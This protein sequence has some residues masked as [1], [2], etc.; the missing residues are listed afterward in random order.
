MKRHELIE[1]VVTNGDSAGNKITI[2]DIEN[3]RN[4]ATQ[5]I[6]ITGIQAL[7][8][9]ALPLSP[10]GNPVWT[11]A[12]M[13]N[14]FLT[15]YINNEESVLTLPCVRLNN[16]FESSGTGTMFQQFQPIPFE[17]LMVSWFKSYF[18]LAA[19]YDTGTTFSIILSVEYKKLAPGQWKQIQSKNPYPGL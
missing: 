8:V 13:Q 12:Q 1:V 5:D 19:P 7:T 18:W 4:D 6:I 11:T 10:Q 17:N 14:A 3:L 2:G 15:L 9:E 16:M